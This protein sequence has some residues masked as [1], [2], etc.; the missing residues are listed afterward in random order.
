MELKPFNKQITKIFNSHY[1]LLLVPESD[2][3]GE[4]EY[5]EETIEE[6]DASSSDIKRVRRRR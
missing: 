1:N 2:S 3:D 4:Y 5:I 6:E